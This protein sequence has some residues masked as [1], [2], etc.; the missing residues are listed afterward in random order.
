MLRSLTP[1]ALLR[2]T[3]PA[4]LCRGSAACITRGLSS[5]IRLRH[6]TPTPPSSL[7]VG[8]VQIVEI[9]FKPLPAHHAQQ[10]SS[11][12]DEHAKPSSSDDHSSALAVHDASTSISEADLPILTAA[13]L[14]EPAQRQRL[15]ADV[16]AG[17]SPT[18]PA[19]RRFLVNKKL[20]PSLFGGGDGAGAAMPSI[21]AGAAI[22]A[23][24]PTSFSGASNNATAMSSAASSSA[25]AV[26]AASSSSSLAA[27]AASAPS[28]PLSSLL[29]HDSASLRRR[30]ASTAVAPKPVYRAPTDSE[31]AWLDASTT[32]NWEAMRSVLRSDPTLDFNVADPHTGASALHQ[33]AALGADAA[34]TSLLAAAGAR[35]HLDA[36]ASNL[37][38]PLH[39]CAGNGHPSTVSLLLS[40][41]ADPR[42]RSVTWNHTVFG[43]GSGQT[44]AH[45]AAESG[46]LACVQLLHEASPA[47]AAM[48]DER[49]A[50]PLE[51]AQ[52]AAQSEV[53]RFLTQ[54]QAE[55][56]VCVEIAMRWSGERIV[57]P[58]QSQGQTNGRGGSGHS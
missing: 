16:A 18:A 35:L 1:A 58:N 12:N 27:L 50:S 3:A 51:A 26:A 29:S 32:G 53:A 36:R 9:A 19:A 7:F 8:Q 44:P 46:H 48:L 38:T 43:R 20:L 10:E 21:A 30:S 13:Q 42:L 55:E 49:Q 25:V 47:T 24:L 28:A 56:Y 6:R 34:I 52:K 54:A 39:W 2:L 15:F 31:R 57:Q 22:Q 40:A 45:W 5:S 33:L 14:S 23:A 11:H 37:A 4:A 41:G 17:A